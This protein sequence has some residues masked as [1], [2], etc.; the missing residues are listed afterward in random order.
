MADDPLSFI[1]SMVNSP[2][3]IRP[4]RGGCSVDGCDK[5]H[6][7]RGLCAS[8]YGRFRRH[9]DPLLGNPPI[10]PKGAGLRFLYNL[11]QNPPKDRCV[12]WPFG[13]PR[14]YPPIAVN[15]ITKGAHRLSW[16]I[17]HGRE[18]AKD[19]HAAHAPGI[20]HNPRCVNPLHILEASRAEN[21]AHKRIDGT[22][23]RGTRQGVAKLNEDQVRAIRSDERTISA[24]ARSYGMD[25]KTIRQIRKRESWAWLD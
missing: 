15:G 14:G 22:Q 7:A 25:R 4:R 18:M 5:P 24:I 12:T 11:A 13:S 2:E 21:E 6:D 20:C 9:G 19:R 17:Y 1:K 3:K 10:M 16:E 8:H 23:A